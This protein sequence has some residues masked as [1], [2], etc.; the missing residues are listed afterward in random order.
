[1]IV[2]F[3]PPR[4]SPTG[5]R[6]ADLLTAEYLAHRVLEENGIAACRSQLLDFGDRVFLESDRFDRIGA[7]GRRGV[8][9]LFALDSARYGQLDSWT[10]CAERLTT[11]SLLSAEDAERIRFLDAFGTLIANT[12]RHFGNLTLF[13]QY[14]GRFELAPVYD[15]LPMLFAPQD[16]QVPARQFAAVPAT[17]AWLSVWPRALAL[18]EA[19]WDRIAQDPRVSAEF[20]QLSYQS[21]EI[22]RAMP[23]RAAPVSAN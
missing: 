8:V 4:S 21:L 13:D 16:G 11:D 15:M 2:K 22:L 7:N 1:V 20:Q 12:D 14:E 5:E 18:A 3:S 17:A 19:Y 6:W 23:R 10:A 9:S